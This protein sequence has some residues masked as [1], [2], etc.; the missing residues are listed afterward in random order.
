[1]VASRVGVVTG[2]NKGI[3]FSIAQQLLPTVTTL[4][5]ACRDRE[6]GE[7]AARRVGGCAVFEPL[8]ISSE[9][10]IDAFVRL[11]EEKYGQLDVLVNNAAIAF[12][13][14]APE[15]FQQQTEPTLRPNFFGTVR[16]SEGLWPLLEASARTRGEARLVNVA[17]IS[18]RLSQLSP[19]RQHQFSHPSL[20]LDSLVGLVDEF[21]RDVAEGVHA[22]RGWGRSNYGLSKLAVIAY[23]KLKAR[24]A[25]P[26]LL[27]NCCC[28]GYCDTDMASHKGPR[29]PSDGAKNAVML[30]TADCQLQGEFVS[31]YK[32]AQW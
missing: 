11:M 14:A 27:V 3:G 32:V 2:A 4:I 30:A 20:D 12:K 22:E 6:R 18:G 5:L 23:T 25:P 24:D 19:A 21:R 26:G 1:M 15:T 7:A 10:S 31:D 8:D 29:S 16:L 13:A 17:S 28:P 9:A